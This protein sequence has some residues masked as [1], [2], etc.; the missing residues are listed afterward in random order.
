MALARR[1]LSA[2]KRNTVNLLTATQ[3]DSPTTANGWTAG[4]TSTCVAGSTPGP[5]GFGTSALFTAGASG[6]RT[7]TLTTGVFTDGGVKVSIFV[8]VGTCTSV[9][10][11]VSDTSNSVLH[12]ASFSVSGGVITPLSS[13]GGMVAS[14]VMPYTYDNGWVRLEAEF[15]PG[16]NGGGVTVAASNLQF[17]MQ[18]NGTSSTC[19]LWGALMENAV[20]A[21]YVKTTADG[22]ATEFPLPA[23]IQ[24]GPSASSA[25][26][27]GVDLLV[28]DDE[29]FVNHTTTSTRYHLD[30]VRGKAIFDTPPANGHV[31]KCARRGDYATPYMSGI[32]SGVRTNPAVEQQGKNSYAGKRAYQG[33]EL[34]FWRTQRVKDEQ[35]IFFTEWRNTPSGAMKLQ[36][37]SAPDAPWFDLVSITQA[38]LTSNMYATL[39]ALMPEMR[40][41]LP[42]V[43]N[44]TVTFTAWVEE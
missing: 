8:K 18:I 16:A 42:T 13:S 25:L 40:I 5:Y 43:G 29:V 19:E 9:L 39:V 35:G 15:I 4:G 38:N 17:Y 11:G 6:A 1:L 21:D 34:P 28:T 7:L 31:I 33:N 12:Y 36:G 44:T 3:A 22:V 26:Q 32:Q 27:D 20:A 10:L 37:R 30:L 41:V 14:R 2:T 23:G 24:S